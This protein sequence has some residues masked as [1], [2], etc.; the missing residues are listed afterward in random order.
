[1]K[2]INVIQALP[3]ENQPIEVV[4]RKGIGHPDT[5]V[6]SIVDAISIELNK[7][8]IRKFGGILHYN[9]DKALLA[10]GSSKPAF[11]GGIIEKPMLIIFGDRATTSL[12]GEA[13][14][15]DSLAKK[16][17]KNWIKTNLR[18]LDVDNHIRFQS[19][20]GKSAGNLSDI[21]KR[22]GGTFLGANDTSA[23]VGYAPLT[24]TERIVLGLERKLNSNEFKKQ[25][26]ETGEDIKVMAVRIKNKLDIT[27]SMAFLDR[28]IDSELSYFRKKS[29][30]IDQIKSYLDESPFAGNYELHLNNLDVSGRGEDGLYLTVTGTSAESGDSG[31]V[32][33]GN[34]VNGLIS[35]VRPSGSEAA[36][37]KNPVSHVGKIYNLLSFEIAN[38]IYRR[39]DEVAEV[40]VWLVSRI[41]QPVNIPSNIAVQVIPKESSKENEIVN[42]VSKILEETLS[43]SYLS[44]FINR[45]IEGKITV[46]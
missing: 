28:F 7:E 6:D 46:C 14:D 13:V 5:I 18:F 39:T 36:A 8:Y 19:E 22:K 9:L 44:E 32:G 24:K 35:L 43:E 42:K 12:N 20:I 26:P 27:V 34:R 17:A 15:I 4:E 31:Q 41:G 1:M 3:V 25:F 33:R 30:V 37:G 40:Y 45:L 23:A 10:A 11:G 2:F 16:V 38:S 29:E 21:F